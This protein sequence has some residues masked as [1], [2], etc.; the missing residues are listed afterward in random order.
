MND[1]PVEVHDMGGYF[2]A[3]YRVLWDTKTLHAA[4]D[5]KGV[6]LRFGDRRDA[7]IAAYQARDIAEAKRFT[8]WN[9]VDQVSVAPKFYEARSR[10]GKKR[11]AE[12][13]IREAM[14]EVAE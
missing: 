2:T 1:H 4:C 11:F 9:G 13:Q 6:V 8:H 7:K 5:E 12:Q 10:A 3:H 14:R